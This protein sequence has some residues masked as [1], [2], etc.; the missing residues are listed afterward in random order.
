MERVEKHIAID[1]FFSPFHRIGCRLRRALPKAIVFYLCRTR[2]R[3]YPLHHLHTTKQAHAIYC[4]SKALVSQE[5]VLNSAIFKGFF[6][7]QTTIAM[8][9]FAILTR[10]VCW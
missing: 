5:R 1:S 9:Q 7:M 3:L 10:I 8:D 2:S 6:R 4:D